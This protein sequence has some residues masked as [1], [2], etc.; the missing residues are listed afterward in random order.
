MCARFTQHSSPARISERFNISR[1]IKFPVTG[2]FIVPSQDAAIVYTLENGQRVLDV[3]KFGLVTQWMQSKPGFKPLI[4][5]RAET[6]DTRPAFR[7]SFINKRCLI[8]ATGFFEWKEVNKAKLPYYFTVKGTDLFSFAGIWE[9]SDS[10]NRS[11]FSTF[12]IITVPANELVSQVH[13][14][15]PVILTPET[16]NLWLGNDAKVTE[17]KGLLRA[18]SAEQMIMTLA[19]QKQ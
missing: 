10:S 8:P 12:A 6:I 18:Y 14:R 11:G 7:D 13:P 2:D 16:E 5:A 3:S 19:K 15:M 1:I 9:A 4:N 17:L